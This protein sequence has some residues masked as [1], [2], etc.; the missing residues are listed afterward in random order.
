MPQSSKVVAIQAIRG[1]KVS[2]C[3]GCNG[4]TTMGDKHMYCTK[5]QLEYSDP[6]MFDYVYNNS[7]KGK[8]K[9]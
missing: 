5:F 4:F 3:S 1:T 2:N 7:C 8:Y 9:T 6:E